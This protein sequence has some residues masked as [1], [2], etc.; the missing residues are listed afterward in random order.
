M[1]P[2]DAELEYLESTG[3][4]WIKTEINAHT[5]ISA[6]VKFRL[7]S[8][9][10]GQ[11]VYVL[12]VNN[13]QRIYFGTYQSKW[14]FGYNGYYQS[15]GIQDNTDYI[16][17]IDWGWY[18]QGLKVNGNT[19]IDLSLTNVISLDMD[20]LLFA[21]QETNPTFA[22]SGRI[23][24][25]KIYDNGKLVGDFIPVRVGTEG[26]MYDKV[27]GKTYGSR[28]ST[29]FVLGPETY[30]NA[31]NNVM[32]L[33]SYQNKW[34]EGEIP[35]ITEGLVSMW[36]GENNAG[37]GIHEN[38][39][40]VWKN[41]VDGGLDVYYSPPTSSD[42]THGIFGDKFF[43]TTSSDMFVNDENLRIIPDDFTIEVVGD[44]FR[45]GANRRLLG[46][47]RSSSN[48]YLAL[49][50]WSLSIYID[51][52]RL[53]TNSDYRTRLSGMPNTGPNTPLHP[54]YIALRSG[55][56]GVVIGKRGAKSTRRDFPNANHFKTWT[57]NKNGICLGNQTNV[58]YTDPVKLYN[59]RIYNRHL[60]DSELEANFKID[61]SRF[62]VSSMGIREYDTSRMTWMFDGIENSGWGI[63][64]D[65][66]R[67][68]K[69][70]VSGTYNLQLADSPNVGFSE[71]ALVK[72]WPENDPA[73]TLSGRFN[74]DWEIC[75]RLVESRAISAQYRTIKI[76]WYGVLLIA[77]PFDGKV[78]VANTSGNASPANG[79]YLPKN[80]NPEAGM[81]I[82]IPQKT[83]NVYCNGIQL[84]ASSDTLD[85][86]GLTNEQRLFS[87][88]IGKIHSI[89][90]YSVA[91]SSN[92]CLWNYEIDKSR[93]GIA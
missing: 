3:S 8:G 79:F 85:F 39:L 24:Y 92:S 11:D 41:L 28:T 47:P 21:R 69:D 22:M 20:F 63:H 27:T 66:A 72:T 48:P 60:S 54:T 36:D 17:D 49:Q 5:G 12:A 64:D 52:Y 62:K 42:M 68:W 82:A 19:L 4:Q 1:K 86:S 67:I 88:C 70:L 38:E 84:E 65:N 6:R 35:Y 18:H 31:G 61:D 59:V 29:P 51:S 40:S 80:V 10:V 90:A 7:S 76:G 58:G 14:Q 30:S 43:S 46:I 53:L 45:N 75:F 50:Y 33:H 74:Q 2:Y 73:L 83:G 77:C 56:N 23:Y 87:G 78:Y 57:G 93:F 71:N 44:G 81:T 91:R 16:A 89:R 25:A 32:N 15:D 13:L 37:F 55:E 26:R 9:M 34:F